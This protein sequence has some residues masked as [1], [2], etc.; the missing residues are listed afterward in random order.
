MSKTE[1]LRQRLLSLQSAIQLN[2]LHQQASQSSEEL[3]HLTEITK[4]DAIY[5]IDKVSEI[6]VLEWFANNWPENE[7]IEVLMEGIKDGSTTFPHGIPLEDTHYVCIIDPIDG[8]RC[9]MD[10][11][12]SG[13]VLTAL[14][15]RVKKDFRPELKD[16]IVAAMTE[17]PTTKQRL[18]D[19]VSGVRGLGPE[20]IVASRHNLDTN[21]SWPITLRP[22][23]ARDLKHGHAI[24]A[25]FFPEAKGLL[26]EVEEALLD[27][28]YGLGK[29]T[30]P[31]V[32]D[33]QY[34]STGGQFYELL[35]GKD[36]MTLDIRPLAFKKTGFDKCLAAHPYDICTALLLQ[37]MGCPIT[38]MQGE[39]L[40]SPLDTTTCVGFQAYANEE[41]RDT[42]QPIMDE[43][44]QIYLL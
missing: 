14:A 9:L 28:L 7:P 8:T 13:W 10:D 34:P 31:I 41:L 44:L 19:Q 11:K 30:Y 1:N 5:Q 2:V 26:T 22:S 6:F 15:P 32:F 3:S 43:L 33:D 25:K 37:E 4:A 29:T 38:G 12:R 17:L 27:R 23:Q 39:P 42:I 18:A 20:G 24:F 16:I 40:N 36:R 35:S 21:E